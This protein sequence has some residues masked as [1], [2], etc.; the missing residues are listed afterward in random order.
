MPTTIPAAA[1]SGF[2]R[3]SAYDAHR[4]SYPAESV[5][6]LL[7]AMRVAS[8]DG[9][10][11]LEIGAG[12]GKFTSLLAAREERFEIVSVEPHAEMRAVLVGKG[13]EGV[14]VVEGS[15]SDLGA[16]QDGWANAVVV[17]Q[18]SLDSG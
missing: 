6:K 5:Q 12:T 15:A 14:R 11:I 7:N 17:A 3:A 8:A 16:I 1:Q 13:L 2:Q 9:A 4:P 18:V 10:R